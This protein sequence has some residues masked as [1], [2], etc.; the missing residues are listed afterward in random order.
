[1]RSQ[2][3]FEKQRAHQ[4]SLRLY[5]ARL[6][7]ASR[8]RQCTYYGPTPLPTQTCVYAGP[9]AAPP[10]PTTTSPTPSPANMIGRE[11]CRVGTTNTATVASS[12][13]SSPTA[14]IGHTASSRAGSGGGTGLCS[15]LGPGSV[16]IALKI[17]RPRCGTKAL[18][19][20]R[21]SQL[22]HRFDVTS[23]HG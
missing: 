3:V 4:D 2:R 14:M 17:A 18:A 9:S 15:R 5:E 21:F 19:V 22:V 20:C 6:L 8:V 16:L 12:Q 7:H 23:R 1:M 10:P 13:P 11:L